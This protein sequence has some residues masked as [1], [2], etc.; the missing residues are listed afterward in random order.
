[1]LEQGTSFDPLADENLGAMVIGLAISLILFGVVV[2]Q[3][4]GYYQNFGRDRVFI[5]V[6]ATVVLLVPSALEVMQTFTITHTIYRTTVTL[7]RVPFNGP[8]SYPLTTS[9]ILEVLITAIVQGFFAFRIYRLS[10]T[11]W[12]SGVCWVLG[13][14]R[15]GGGLALAAESYR[16]VPREPNTTV[17]TV[18]Y[19]WLITLSLIVGALV[20]VLIAGSLCF[21][22]KRIVTPQPSKSASQLVDRLIGWTVQ[23]G[24]ITRFHA[25]HT[26][27]MLIDSLKYSIASVS[28]VIAFTVVTSRNLVRDLYGHFKAVL[29]LVFVSLNLR[30]HHRQDVISVTLSN[31][32]FQ[33]TPQMDISAP[34]PG[35]SFRAAHDHALGPSPTPVRLFCDILIHIHVLNR[36][37][38]SPFPQPKTSLDLETGHHVFPGMDL[39]AQQSLNPPGIAMTPHIRY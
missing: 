16:D 34:I 31:L 4:Y 24:I 1:M 28:V 2:V 17:L 21:Y 25:P 6:L 38:S 39:E 26:T 11:L 37:S 22:L 7:R 29:Q 18:T 14:L 27:Q 13:L 33:T 35:A 36:A 5:K 3:S 23:T 19:A 30:S 32:Q 15:L 8:N 20:D 12:I 9:V 10:K